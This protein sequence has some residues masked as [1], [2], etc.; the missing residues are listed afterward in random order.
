MYA[1]IDPLKRTN[2]D[3]RA[4]SYRIPGHHLL[5]AT[6][7]WSGNFNAAS[8]KL[9]LMVFARGNNLLGTQYIERGKDGASH[10]LDSFRGFWGFGRNFSFGVRFNF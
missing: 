6:L 9:G 5:G 2:P 10:D 4:T 1:D 3:D 7:C 8:H